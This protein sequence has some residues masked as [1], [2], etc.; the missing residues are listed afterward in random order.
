MLK[1]ISKQ[2]EKWAFG[3]RETSRDSIAVTDSILERWIQLRQS[4]PAALAQPRCPLFRWF[5]DTLA[6]VFIVLC[7]VGCGQR[8]AEDY[9]DDGQRLA[10]ELTHKLK[11]IRT[12]EQLQ[13]AQDAIKA[14][15]DGLVDLMIRAREWRLRHPQ[16]KELD[17]L[18]SDSVNIDLQAQ[19]RR[20]SRIA[21]CLEILEK[22]QDGAL[23]RLDKF[24]KEIEL[25]KS[26]AGPGLDG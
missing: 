20:V 19:L 22:C 26:R 11:A 15:F 18:A 2:S 9:R 3:Q 1:R 25:R 6:F 14:D 17:P 13:A 24:E 8:S 12:K 23:N 21:G 5:G 16:T 7:L 10:T 4:N